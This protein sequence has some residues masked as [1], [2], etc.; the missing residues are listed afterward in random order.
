[1][2][3]TQ[4]SLL[5]PNTT[6]RA[7]YS[8]LLSQI[9]HKKAVITFIT[10]GTII[11]IFLRSLI[12]L[13]IGNVI[14]IIDN[15]LAS[16]TGDISVF[17]SPVVTI[18][19]IMLTIVLIRGALVYSVNAINDWLAFKVES[20]VREEFYESM[21]SKPLGFHDSTR[22]GN[23]MALATNDTR[24]MSGLISPG[25]RLTSEFFISITF[26]AIL[27]VTAIDIRLSFICLFFIPPYLWGI[28]RYGN[29]LGPISRV[30]QMQFSD[31]SVK[32]QDSVVGAKIV[33][34]F[35]GENFETRNFNKAA[36]AFRDTWVD[37]QRVQ[38]RYY[39]TLVLFMA[40]AASTLAGSF[41][42]LQ[43]EMTLGG[44]V[45]FNGLL[46]TLEGPTGVISF[47]LAITQ[48]GLAGS[49]RIYVMMQR[50]DREEPLKLLKHKIAWPVEVLGRVEFRNLTFSYER[51]D[52]PVLK[53]ISF[54]AEPGEMIAI[55]GP[56]GCG[57]STLTKLLLRF[58]EPSN[59][60]IL[61]DDVN[62]K[63]YKLIDLRKHIGHIEQDVFL[64]STSIRN[65]IAFGKASATREE[66]ERVA[67]AAQAHDFI[68]SFKDGYDTVVGERGHT[69]SGGQRQ[70]VAIARA[71]ITNPEILI[72]DDSTSAIDSQTEEK[73]VSVIE[74]LVKGR[75]S[76][77]ITHRIS[78][79][80]KADR[81]IVI[82][83]GHAVAQG[84]H[85]DLIRTSVDYRRIFG[86]HV[87]LPPLEVPI[88]PEVESA[89]KEVS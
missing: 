21:Q 12:P 80:M 71:F 82:K 26:V 13:F 39:P 30:F 56:T 6:K 31:I 34:A 40:I 70:R 15:A 51:N 14:D 88:V 62:I 52:P 38:E 44:L 36:M 57:K 65:N 66:I 19:G 8:W 20:E 22:T 72:L 16:P 83:R 23:I 68:T 74:S 55:V 79:I 89:I 75:T 1:M 48:G 25:L 58:Y 53:D 49:A 7:F 84:R 2:D 42:V 86:K 87:I 35:S 73:I 3:N 4:K 9:K 10:F 37:R 60:Q 64:F 17:I 18:S 29:Q 54:T 24:Q 85:E 5:P 61:L 28:R 50:S 46:I 77:I 33:R 78:T 69:L 67:K 27:A 59:G 41:L 47:A 43:G 63:K 76:F 81:I 32:A 45:A 11:V